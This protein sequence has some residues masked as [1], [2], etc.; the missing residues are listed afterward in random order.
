MNTV[1]EILKSSRISKK[2]SVEFISAELKISKDQIRR[3]ENDDI[4]LDPDITFNIGHIKSYSNYMDLNTSQ[5]V[6]QFKKQIFFTKK[7]KPEQIKQP[8]FT[9]NIIKK[10]HFFSTTIIIFIFC[11]FYFLFIDNSKNERQY[12]LVPD[13]PE[14]YIP[15]IEESN[16]NNSTKSRELDNENIIYKN[17]TNAVAS[18]E[19]DKFDIES[20]ITLRLTNP[21]WIQI[22]N[23]ENTIILSKLME[24]NE[25]FSYD[26][27]LEYSITS[28]NAGNIIVIIDEKVLG[29][30]GKYG[31]VVDTFIIDKNFKN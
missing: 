19:Q 20:K 11:L 14:S 15:I 3:I 13:L 30:I 5:I 6:E 26:A 2:L 23:K 1:G 8:S 21:T 16:L 24:K 12:A 10:N 29:K 4:F 25:E 18:V 31:E 17:P 7:I 27:K 22:R 28:G 9:N